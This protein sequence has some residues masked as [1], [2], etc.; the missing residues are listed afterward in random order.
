MPPKGK[1]RVV[2]MLHEAHP[3]IVQM[4]R[5]ARGYV[6][7]PGIDVELEKCVKSAKLSKRLL[8]LLPCTHGHGQRNHGQEFMLIMQ[9]LSWGRCSS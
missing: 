3:G 2:K 1:S 4:K 5:L 6:W 9:F 8:Q 7:W